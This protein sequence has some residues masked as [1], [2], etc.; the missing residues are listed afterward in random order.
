[1][2]RKLIAFEY[3]IQCLVNWFAETNNTTQENALLH[4][5]KL[6]LF[7]LLFFV[8]AIN[9]TTDA[10]KPDLLD[11]FNKFYALP[12]GPVEGDVYNHITELNHY[13]IHNDHVEIKKPTIDLQNIEELRPLIDDSINALRE[14]NPHIVTLQAFDLVNISHKWPVWKILY[15]QAQ[16]EGRRQLPMDSDLIR[17]SSKFFW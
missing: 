5:N 6:K 11:T 9:S 16:K 7:K 17:I 12:Y 8:S 15:A 3:I 13:T 2:T 1:M 14:Q 4:F 10:G